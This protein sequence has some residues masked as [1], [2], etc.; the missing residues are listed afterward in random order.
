[1]DKVTFRSP[2]GLRLPFST[3]TLHFEL[4]CPIALAECVTRLKKLGATQLATDIT[5]VRV[6]SEIQRFQLKSRAFRVHLLEAP[7][8]VKR[9]DDNNTQV[10]GD[11][12]SQSI[13]ALLFALT[14]VIVGALAI[15]LANLWIMFIGLVIICLVGLY[16]QR[17]AQNA[18]H[19]QRE[20]VKQIQ[21][22]LGLT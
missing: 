20:L 13:A 12:F 14:F 21:A 1:M 8:F 5:F 7:G 6:D 9:I 2:T 11:V 18:H 17:L 19:E 15:A 3:N 22:V 16:C 4:T 10:T